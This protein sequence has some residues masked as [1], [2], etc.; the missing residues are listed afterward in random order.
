MEPAECQR[1][2]NG[3][4]T[5]LKGIAGLL[6]TVMDNWEQPHNNA[7]LLKPARHCHSVFRALQGYEKAVW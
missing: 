7:T 6:M 3:H 1:V 5:T 4:K 2:F